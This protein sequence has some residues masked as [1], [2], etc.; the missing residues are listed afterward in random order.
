MGDSQATAST[1]VV[2][3]YYP[4]NAGRLVLR[5]DLDWNR[6]LEADSTSSDGTQWTFRF[7][8]SEPFHYFK[9]CLIQG[10][11][12]VWST[13]SNYLTTSAEGV[14]ELYPVFFSDVKGQITDI[15]PL[16]SAE[17]G[18][19]QHIRI[20]LPPGYQENTLKRYPVLYMHDGTNLFF[21]QESFLG[22]DWDVE[23][24]A[25]LL[26]SMNVINKV[27]VVGI[28]AQDRMKEYTRSGHG[29]YGRFLVNE[30]KPW[31]DARVRTLTGPRETGVMGSS[32]GGLVSFYLGWQYPEV[33]GM[34]GCLSSTFG[35][36]DDLFDRVK[37]EARRP[38]RFYM[39][40]GY[41]GDNFEVT[42]AMR[43]LML[44]QGYVLGT[45]L[46]TLVYPGDLHNEKYWATRLHVPFQFFFSR[47]PEFSVKPDPA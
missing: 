20:Y 9:P 34:A 2:R 46:M 39:D 5:T 3:V 12:F 44:K 17:L 29:P 14:R 31:L 27:I 30:L 18:S 32:L 43:D 11:R 41:P 40:S 23:T 21:P 37:T 26:N 24:T 36:D 47:I 13:G 22:V 38:V 6:N 19:R 45:D 33:F 25:D 16:D 8:S 7:V 42:R 35:Y 28:Y 1:Y 4:M 10:E 15:I